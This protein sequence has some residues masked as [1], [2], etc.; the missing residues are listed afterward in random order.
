MV[1]YVALSYDILI[2]IMEFI[3]RF[4]EKLKS[5]ILAT[6]F[7]QHLKITNVIICHIKVELW[8]IAMDSKMCFT[9]IKSLKFKVSAFCMKQ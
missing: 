2:H 6:Y 7:F 5:V 8:P 4:E 9:V 3:N 1:I